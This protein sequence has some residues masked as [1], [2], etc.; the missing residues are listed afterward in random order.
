MKLIFVWIKFSN[1]KMNFN[2]EKLIKT[3]FRFFHAR[4]VV[5]LN[6]FYLI[7]IGKSVNECWMEVAMAVNQKSEIASLRVH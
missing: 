7:S 4:I 6:F 3:F 5:K 1:K 2:G